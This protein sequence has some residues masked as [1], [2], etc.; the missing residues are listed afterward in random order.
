MFNELGIPNGN[1]IDYRAP[2]RIALLGT[3]RHTIYDT[4]DK[5]DLR[6][7][8]EVIAIGALSS[9]RILYEENW[10]SHRTQG[11]PACANITSK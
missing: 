3:Y 1:I 9:F 11:K 5:I 10:P 7:L 6:S 2:G 4:L 8:R